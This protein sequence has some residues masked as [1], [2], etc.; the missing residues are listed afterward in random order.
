MVS[1]LQHTLDWLLKDLAD[2]TGMLLAFVTIE[3]RWAGRFVVVRDFFLQELF[4]L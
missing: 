1:A 3:M 4:C 2:A